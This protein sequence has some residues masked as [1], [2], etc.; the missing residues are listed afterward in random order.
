MKILI[1]NDVELGS[2]QKMFNG[3]FPFLKLCF[4]KHLP[5]GENVY[6]RL[7]IVEDAGTTVGQIS[8]GFRAGYWH[9][10]PEQKTGELEKDCLGNLGLHMQVFRKSGKVWIETSSSDDQTLEEQDRNGRESTVKPV[11]HFPN[12]MDF[13]HEQA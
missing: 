1:N 11:T 6:N 10:S 2:I 9:I 5:K 13:Y 4:F 12:D 3:E 7:N 8:S